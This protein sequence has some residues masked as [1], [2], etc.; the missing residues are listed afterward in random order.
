MVDKN[1][2]GY[3]LERNIKS[4][5]KDKVGGLGYGIN[6]RMDKCCINRSNG[7]NLSS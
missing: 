2:T 6:L 3:Q 7:F 1:Q 5:L 4:F